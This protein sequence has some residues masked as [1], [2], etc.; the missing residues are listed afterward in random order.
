MLQALQD[1]LLFA[2]FFIFL[3]SPAQWITTIKL[4]VKVISVICKGITV[5]RFVKQVQIIVAT[6]NKHS[7]LSFVT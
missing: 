5:G 6:H 2:R 1:F 4:C 3:K 7:L